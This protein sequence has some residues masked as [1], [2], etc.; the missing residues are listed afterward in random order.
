VTRV[1]VAART[2]GERLALRRR[3][4][5]PGIDVVGIGPTPDGA[6]AAVDVVVI[7][8]AE[9]LWEATGPLAETGARSLVALADDDR[10]ARTL[11]AMRLRGWAIVSRDAPTGE[12]R[13][14]IMAAAQGFTV[15]PTAL[16]ARLLPARDAAPGEARAD[17]PE[18]LTAREREVLELLAEGLS[19]RQVAERLG[20]SEH[21]AKF[22][23]ASVSG[24]LGA[25][26][27]TEAVSR[28]VRRGLISL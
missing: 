21:T 19:N 17:Q 8:D 25:S 7:A 1:F 10:P 4:D 26:S 13:A 2:L 16:A 20:I 22:H 18:P 3:L 9:L 28:G 6:P 24:K 11:R 5:G 12:L 23:V 15:V 14:A 27:R